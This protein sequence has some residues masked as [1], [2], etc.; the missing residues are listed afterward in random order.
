MPR[1]SWPVNL[2][3]SEVSSLGTCVR[4]QGGMGPSAGD[5]EL[6]KNG[7]REL[8]PG[9]HVLILYS[10]L[11]TTN[12]MWPVLWSHCHCNYPLW[13]TV[14]WNCET[15]SFS[16]KLPL[17]RHFITA[18][19]NETRTWLILASLNVSWG[20]FFKHRRYLIINSNFQ[21]TVQLLC[22]S[23]ESLPTIRDL[24]QPLSSLSFS[25]MI[26]TILMLSDN[27]CWNYCTQKHC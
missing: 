10:L 5:P 21:M 4:K 13:L 20:F 26:S 16:L 23:P 2:T 17:S 22:R 24:H 9:M 19:G 14:T 12:I 6:C 25:V 3:Y 8:S 7:E 11:L 15:N 1:A 18:T 27:T